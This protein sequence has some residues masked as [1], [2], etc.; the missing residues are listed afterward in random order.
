MNNNSNRL[1]PEQ[2]TMALELSEFE[3]AFHRLCPWRMGQLCLPF[4][5]ARLNDLANM[6]WSRMPGLLP[7]CAHDPIGW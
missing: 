6:Q 5:R 1:A 3:P 2:D 7:K 4:D